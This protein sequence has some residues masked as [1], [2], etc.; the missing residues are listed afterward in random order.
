MN[1]SQI[2]PTAEGAM[3]GDYLSTSIVGGNG[4]ALFAVGTVS[5]NGQHFNEGHVHGQR[6]ARDRRPTAHADIRR[7][8]RPAIREGRRQ[9]TVVWSP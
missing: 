9:A 3:A 1:L 6:A 8:I 5:T 4:V 2:A 7:A